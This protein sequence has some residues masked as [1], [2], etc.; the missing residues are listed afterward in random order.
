M[1]GVLTAASGGQRKVGAGQGRGAGEGECVLCD[2][3]RDG[4][5]GGGKRDGEGEQ[6]GRMDEKT[7]KDGGRTGRGRRDERGAKEGGTKQLRERGKL[8]RPPILV[9][10][11]WSLP[12]RPV[13][14]AVSF[15]RS[16]NETCT[17][18]LKRTRSASCRG[19]EDSL[20]KLSMQFAFA[21]APEHQVQRQ[22]QGTGK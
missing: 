8:S 2:S 7:R 10:L 9:L 19:T 6:D 16:W 15:R 1:A 13:Q 14:A 5:D 22:Q 12:P 4:R 21:S 17:V 18:R 11:S 3:G 20:H